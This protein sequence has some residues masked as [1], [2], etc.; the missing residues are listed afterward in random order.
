M[1]GF[2]HGVVLRPRKHSFLLELVKLGKTALDIT[3]IIRDGT[4]N[5]EK[6]TFTTK[7]QERLQQQLKADAKQNGFKTAGEKGEEEAKQSESEDVKQEQNKSHKQEQDK[8]IKQERDEGA[9]LKQDKDIRQRE[10]EGAQ[11]IAAEYAVQDR[12]DSCSDSD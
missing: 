9:K 10:R 6:D 3:A 2:L 7:W 12:Y 4:T 11:A 8:G 5:E 1:L